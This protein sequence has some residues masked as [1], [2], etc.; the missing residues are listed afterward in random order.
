VA[1]TDETPRAGSVEELTDISSWQPNV[2]LAAMRRARRQV[3]LRAGDGGFTDPYFAARWRQAGQLNFDFRWAYHFARP[4]DPN[5]QADWFLSRVHAGG[6]WRAYG[7]IAMLDCEWFSLAGIAAGQDPAAF[8]R[9]ATLEGNQGYYTHHAGDPHHG[10]PSNQDHITLEGARLLIPDEHLEQARSLSWVGL[11]PNSALGYARAWFAAVRRDNPNVIPMI[12][13]NGWYLAQARITQQSLPN[14]GYVIASYGSGF[15]LPPGWDHACAWQYTDNGRV[16]GI[17][18]GVDM[19]KVLCPSR[20]G[21]LM[22]HNQPHDQGDSVTTQMPTITLTDTGHDAFVQMACF[23]LAKDGWPMPLV[24][25]ARDPRWAAGIR[26]V[27]NWAGLHVD[28]VV[29]EDTWPAVLKLGKYAHKALP[30]MAAHAT[31]ETLHAALEDQE[32]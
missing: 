18:S 27:Q 32:V 4:G 20:Y 11:D 5:Q 1:E 8:V 31:I 21:H 23:K 2:D 10:V 19:N 15:S 22:Q 24:T 29:G 12:Y 17:P 16:E 9:T 3:S 6:G 7:D 14:V 13:G 28:G 30:R 25:N 26:V